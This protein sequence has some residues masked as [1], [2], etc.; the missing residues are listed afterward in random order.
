[1]TTTHEIPTAAASIVLPAQ[2]AETR[3]DHSQ[4]V[5]RSRG[6]DVGEERLDR[7]GDEGGL[8]D[9]AA[10]S[11]RPASVAQAIRYRKRAQAAERG[12]AEAQ[13]QLAQLRDRLA[14]A[15]RSVA[16]LERRQ[17]IDALLIEEGAVDLDAA[18][19]LAERAADAMSEPDAAAA[20]AEVKRLKPYL[21]RRG[22]G[23]ATAFGAMAPRMDDEAT[24]TEQAAQ[25]AAE[26]GDRRDLLAYLRLRRRS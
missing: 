21:F 4:I 16:A 7:E 15:Q 2:P 6:G 20:V 26:T 11:E 3:E 10:E 24:P 8:P 9:G 12:F 23:I 13:Q 19:L 18:R 22:D 1:M 17:R 25:R 14:E 5:E